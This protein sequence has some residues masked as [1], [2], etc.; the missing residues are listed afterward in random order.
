MCSIAVT[1]PGTP[2]QWFILQPNSEKTL[3]VNLAGVD[4]E[5][6]LDDFINHYKK[7]EEYTLITNPPWGEKHSIDEKILYNNL[8]YFIN[9]SIS[10]VLLV[11]EELK[12]ALKK[13]GQRM[14]E[15]CVTRIRG[16]LAT[17]LHINPSS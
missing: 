1:S 6:H 7:S 4:V 12:N 10:S 2:V 13:T 14:E 8:R 15:V 17:I 11:P 5:L 9:G 3:N 16:K